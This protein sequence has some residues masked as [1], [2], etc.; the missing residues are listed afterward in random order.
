MHH[1]FFSF[2]QRGP[3]H[4]AAKE[5]FRY[6]VEALVKKEANIKFKDKKGVSATSGIVL[7]I[8]V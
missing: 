6:T 7:L 4:I 3:L 1:I 2:N 8:I 5:G